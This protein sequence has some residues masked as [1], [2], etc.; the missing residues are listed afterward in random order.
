ML[1]LDLRRK[2]SLTH[3]QMAV[4]LAKDVRTVERYCQCD[5]TIPAAVLNYCYLLD[6]YLSS[7][8]QLPPYAM[9]LPVEV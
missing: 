5:R 8:K 6:F 1:P 4:L 9:L 3:A 7:A 2:Y